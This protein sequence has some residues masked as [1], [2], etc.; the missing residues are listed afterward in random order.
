MASRIGFALAI[1]SI[2]AW[3]L[4]LGWFLAVR[5][6]IKLEELHLQD[7]FGVAYSAYAGRTSRLIPGL[8]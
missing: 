4:V 2:L 1:P 5:R 7:V 3:V 6:R 8:Y